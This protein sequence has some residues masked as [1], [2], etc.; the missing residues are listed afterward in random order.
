MTL[1]ESSYVISKKF[2][3]RPASSRL[4]LGLEELS[5]IQG[6][7]VLGQQNPKHQLIGVKHLTIYRLSTILKWW[8]RISPPSTV[9]DS[10][11]KS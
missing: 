9:F 10:L 4:F 2:F 7:E 6:S 11:M 5:W 1:R 3:P 8:C